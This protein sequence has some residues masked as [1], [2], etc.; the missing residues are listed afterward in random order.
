MLVSHSVMGELA[1]CRFVEEIDV[2]RRRF[3]E[4]SE[5]RR[6]MSDLYEVPRTSLSQSTCTR[7]GWRDV[8]GC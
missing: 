4:L 1:M 7:A 2:A 8:A 5:N 3:G 6:C